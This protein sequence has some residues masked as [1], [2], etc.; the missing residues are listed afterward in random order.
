MQNNI[1]L[2]EC[3][4]KQIELTYYFRWWTYRKHIKKTEDGFVITEFLPKVP[5]AGKHNTVNLT[6][7]MHLIEGRWL[8]DLVYLDD[9]SAFWYRG[10]GLLRSYTSWLA[11]AILK[12]AYVTGNMNLPVSLLDDM[13]SDYLEWEKGFLAKNNRYKIGGRP[14][15]MY[16]TIDDRDGGEV[17][18]GG[19]GYRP[20]INAAM[21]GYAKAISQIAHDCSRRDIEQEFSENAARIKK[22]FIEKLWDNEK[23]FFMILSEDETRLSD[24]R[25]LYGYAPWFFNMLDS[26]FEECWKHISMLDGFFAPYGLTFPEQRH[27]EFKLKYE[28]HECQWNGPSWPLSTS[29][30]LTAMANLLNQYQ[31]DFVGKRD[32]Y[33][34]LSAYARSHR[35]VL[36]DGRLVPWIDENLNPYTGDWI[37]R[38][39]L[40]TW[41]DNTWSDIKGGI[42]RGKDYNHSSFCDLIITGLVGIRPQI[43]NHL[44]INPLIPENFWDWFCLD[45]VKYHGKLMTL[46]WDKSGEKYRFG[47]GFTVL[48]EGKIVAVSDNLGQ[49]EIDL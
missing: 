47:K 14:N 38:T 19:H 16:Y 11:D 45:R 26:G 43:G 49:I 37:S 28:G 2:F 41:E 34:I 25:E 30:V 3:P 35:R 9:Y 6:A 23:K 39:R 31:Q 13:I 27:H 21:Y 4:D 15:G 20:L 22:L 44:K 24:V 46:M 32:Y 10:G 33:D 29:I 12:R 18:I 5:W 1:P 8:H 42:E 17:S 36:P 7:C 48:C 40:E